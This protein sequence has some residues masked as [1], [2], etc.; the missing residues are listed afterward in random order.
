V[1]RRSIAVLA[2]LLAGSVGL[3]PFAHADELG[4]ET[5]ARRLHLNWLD[6]GRLL[7]SG[8]GVDEAL[9]LLRTQAQSLDL[10]P[11]RVHL[12]DDPE[13]R[14]FSLP[15]GRVYV[16][17][18]LFLLLD[19]PLE[20][21]FVLAHEAAHE[22]DHRSGAG[23]DELRADRAALA[24]LGD[25]GPRVARGVLFALQSWYPESEVLDRRIAALPAAKPAYWGT[26]WSAYDPLRR[27]VIERWLERDRV[28]EARRAL[29]A[30]CGRALGD[31]AAWMRARA[32]RLSGRA[33]LTDADAV[34]PGAEDP[35]VLAEGALWLEDQGRTDEA[36]SLWGKARWPDGEALRRDVVEGA[37]AT[38][39]EPLDP[40]S[41]WDGAPPLDGAW[42]LVSDGGT[43]IWT[44]HGAAVER[45]SWS[46]RTGRAPV[47]EL[48]DLDRRLRAFRR[49]RPWARPTVRVT[50]IPG[51]YRAEFAWRDRQALRWREVQ[52]RITGAGQNLEVSYRAPMLH[53]FRAMDA[54]VDALVR[55]TVDANA[56]D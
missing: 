8:P 22:A 39:R 33:P 3:A 55:S 44:R 23:G 38:D 16:N 14:A 18:G 32:A 24:R 35:R 20:L 17:T 31:E 50:P 28:A 6:R 10:D 5:L 47:P 56:G 49:D 13:P 40:A 53:P 36:R 2:V 1:K 42:R 15:G 41:P 11:A 27:Q 25:D 26:C 52:Y 30:P 45:L 29:A 21:A 7:E 48:L 9:H 54:R 37:A 34:G 46:L 19:D 43:R 51:G 4:R 12:L